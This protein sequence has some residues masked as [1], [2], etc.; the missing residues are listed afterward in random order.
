MKAN[1]SKTKTFR[2][3]KRKIVIAGGSGFLGQILAKHFSQ[4]GDEVII[5]SRSQKTNTKNIIYQTWNGKTLGKWTESL[6]NA[7]V[8]INLAGKSVNCRYNAKNKAEIYSSRL[9]STAV[10]GQAIQRCQNPPKLWLNSSSATIYKHSLDKAMNEHTGEYGTGFSV[11]V[12]KQWEAIFWKQK[13]PHTRK[14]ALRLAMVLG[15]KGGVMI[16]FKN[17]VKRGLGGTQGNGKQHLSW[18]HETDF[19]AMTEFFINHSDLEGNFNCSAPNPISNKDFMQKLRKQLKVSV[20]LPANKI[21]LE[22]GAFFM[23]TETELILKSR[24]VVPTKLLEAGFQFQ[25]PTI[26]LVF[27]D[28]C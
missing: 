26:E 5:L 7:D 14:I 3:M 11:D 6:E 4:K 2:M 16:P 9:E 27:E 24:R 22:I 17:L 21:M 25:Y 1:E 13:T 15:K 10:L 20:G 23:R 18:L 28:L 8:L 19:I 12:C